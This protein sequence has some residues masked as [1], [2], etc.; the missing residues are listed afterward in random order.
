M[1]QFCCPELFTQTVR[2][3]QDGMM[4]RVADN[5]AVSEAFA[6]TKEVREGCVPAP[7]PFS[8][9]LS[10]ML[11]DA[12]RDDRPGIRIAYRSDGQPIN[13]RRMHF[14]SRVTA[15]TVHDLPF[16]NDCGFN[17]TSEGDM[18]RSMDLFAAACNNC[19]LVAP[20]INVNGAELQA[21]DNF[22]YLGSTLSRTT[23]IDDEV[24]RR[25]SKA[26]QAFGR[27]Q[28]RIWNRHDLQLSTKL[29]MYKAVILPTLLYGAETWT[30]YKKLARR[31]T[32]P[33]LTCIRRILKLR[34]QHRIL[35]TDVLKR[36][37]TLSIYVMPR[38]M[39]L[40]WGSHFVWMDDISFMEMS[41]LVSADH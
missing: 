22:T 26:S 4:A 31:L 40:R 23:K 34:W 5:E 17:T 1:Q 29:K 12:Y 8:L 33:H 9:M 6:L 35:D 10:A 18:Q 37:G 11:M 2:H 19:G 32:H 14:Q 39:Q 25:I 36:T 3:L 20:K 15:T 27:L 28:S 30:V 21:V 16:A 24:A 13:H 38:Q 41:P 7:T